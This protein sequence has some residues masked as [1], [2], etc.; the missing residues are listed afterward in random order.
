MQS[1]DRRWPYSFV[2]V[3]DTLNI[4]CDRLRTHILEAPVVELDVA[5]KLDI[6]TRSVRPAHSE[7]A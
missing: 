5:A 2:N 7:A 6:R 3:C 4:P 1:N